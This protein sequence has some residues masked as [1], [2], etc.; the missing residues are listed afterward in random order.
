M[1][2]IIIA[3]LGV[4][5]VLLILVIVKIKPNNNDNKEIEKSLSDMKG[6]IV[7]ENIR[8]LGDL[9]QAITSY[10]DKQSKENNND[11][12]N[13]KQ[14]ITDTINQKNKE[15]TLDL[16]KFKD[17]LNKEISDKF[18]EF[19]ARLELEME[20]INKQVDLRLG[21]GFEKTNQTFNNIVERLSKIDEAQK[22]ISNLSTNIVSLQDVLTDKKSRGTFGEIQLSNILETT[23]GINNSKVFELQ[24]KLSNGTMVDSI[25]H[26]PDPLGDICVDSKF[27]LENYQRMVDSKLSNEERTHASKL[28]KDDIKKHIN[29]ISDKYII[30][31]ETAEQA[32]MFLPSEAIFA[33][34]NAYHPDLIQYSQKKRVWITSPTTLMSMLTTV[35]VVLRNIER[36]KYSKIIFEELERLGQEFDRYRVRW[37]KLSSSIDTVTKSVKEIN[38]TS[39]KITNRFKKI[40]SVEITNTSEDVILIDE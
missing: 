9:K 33:E 1:E 39:E 28:F 27:P 38:T 37:D 10:L 2:E 21:E 31:L 32:I 40:S 25:L 5:I 7:K 13:Y 6:F 23:F 11:L 29:D 16:F 20:K 18:K 8:E 14:S 12:N 19:N 36:E 30:P 35:Q 3:L 34:I 26:L 17:G 15:M 22:Q 4:V 24:K